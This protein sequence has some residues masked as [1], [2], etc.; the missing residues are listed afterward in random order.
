MIQYY[1]WWMIKWILLQVVMIL[2]S[3][4]MVKAILIIKHA[5]LNM[6]P[7]INENKGRHDSGS[8]EGLKFVQSQ[9][10]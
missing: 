10:F 3:S 8:W 5:H 6:P 4:E 7:V 2:C 9:P 1:Y